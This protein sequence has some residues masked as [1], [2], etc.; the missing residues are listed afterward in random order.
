MLADITQGVGVAESHYSQ[1]PV[2]ATQALTPRITASALSR[3]QSSLVPKIVFLP[4]K[5]VCVDNR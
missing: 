3:F 5:G 2:P 1:S 4:L